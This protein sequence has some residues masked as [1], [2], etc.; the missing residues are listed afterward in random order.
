MVAEEVKEAESEPRLYEVVIGCALKT[1]FYLLV[2][3]SLLSGY[4]LLRMPFFAMKISYDLGYTANAYGFAQ[5]FLRREAKA[6]D[7]IT[8]APYDSAYVGGLLYA[9]ELSEKLMLRDK[10]YAGDVALHTE[11]YATLKEADKRNQLLDAYYTDVP[12]PMRVSGYSYRD[13]VY[14]LNYYARL[15]SGRGDK[16]LFGGKLTALSELP[17]AAAALDFASEADAY[18][19]ILNQLG[20]AASL[21]E[22]VNTIA[23]ARFDEFLEFSL[24]CQGLK[25]LFLIKSALGF[26][27]SLAGAGNESFLRQIDG[28][29]LSEY[30]YTVLL[31][32][33]IK[34]NQ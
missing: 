18:A 27:E 10:A 9:I 3:G 4:L 7:D 14:C 13:Y 25:R 8:A 19:T 22:N 28:R 26:A 16:L 6:Y 12:A 2:F 24:G 1:L 23:A 17:A 20:R 32:N 21:G 5:T 29:T 34:N 33:Y 11:T 30:Y 15:V 31:P